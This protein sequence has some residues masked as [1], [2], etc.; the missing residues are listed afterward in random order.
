[1]THQQTTETLEEVNNEMSPSV[2]CFPGAPPRIS[3]TDAC[4]LSW[5]Q[6]RLQFSAL[7]KL[8]VISGAEEIHAGITGVG[9][10]W[11]VVGEQGM[12]GFSFF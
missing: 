2:F 10:L 7:R 9:V 11:R 3:T 1:M 5:S 6:G 4:S 12:S 8:P